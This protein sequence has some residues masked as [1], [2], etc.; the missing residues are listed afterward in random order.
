MDGGLHEWGGV[1]E[2]VALAPVASTQRVAATLGLLRAGLLG[3]A[4]PGDEQRGFPL[5]RAVCQGG[6]PRP[7]RL[8]RGPWFAA[9]PWALITPAPVAEGELPKQRVRFVVELCCIGAR[10]VG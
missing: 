1:E 7:G 8:A 5:T 6:T 2:D 4:A 3:A 9:A 10:R